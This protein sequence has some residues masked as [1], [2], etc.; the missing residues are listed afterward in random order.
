MSKLSLNERIQILSML[1]EGSSGEDRQPERKNISA[2]YAERQNLTTRMHM[3]RFMRL[4]NA[5]SKKFESH[6]HTVALYTVWY[7][8]I[9]THKTLKTTPAVEAGLADAPRGFDFIVGQVEARAPKTAR[10]KKNTRDTTQR[11]TWIRFLH[12]ASMVR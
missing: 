4:T 6:C 2:S 11:A 8:C 3:R 10:P 12:R 5:F 9:R 1:V 7:N